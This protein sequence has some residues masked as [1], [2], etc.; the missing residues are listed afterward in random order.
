[1]G[2][3]TTSGKLT[4]RNFSFDDIESFRAP[5]TAVRPSARVAKAYNE[6]ETGSRS[7]ALRTHRRM[8]VGIEVSGAFR[9]F[10]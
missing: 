5:V 9:G 1:M 3:M 7:E 8:T 2:D 10:S 6:R 4:D